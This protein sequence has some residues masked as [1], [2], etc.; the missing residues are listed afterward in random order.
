MFDI[1]VAID[2][3]SPV[4]SFSVTSLHSIISFTVNPARPA[5]SP[6]LCIL[7]TQHIVH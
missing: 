1:T 3:V 6:S 7:Y 5:A 2:P 4:P